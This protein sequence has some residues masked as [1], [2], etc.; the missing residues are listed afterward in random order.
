VSTVENTALVLRYVQEVLNEGRIESID[1]LC[2]H[3]LLIHV[4]HLPGVLRGPARLK[5]LVNYNRIIFP[6]G[7]VK[8]RGYHRRTGQG[9]RTR[10]VPWDVPRCPIGAQDR[11]ESDADSTDLR[12]SYLPHRGRENR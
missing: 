5:Q 11:R 10:D 6:D 7:H 1:L 8:G 9:L 2:A 3:E 4:P 12:N